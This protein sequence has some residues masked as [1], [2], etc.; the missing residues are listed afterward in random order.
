MI[1]YVYTVELFPT[2]LRMAALGACSGFS[3]IGQ[4]L[5]PWFSIY[6]ME[7]Y[8]FSPFLILGTFG[9]LASLLILAIP[10]ET[11]NKKMESLL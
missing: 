7:I 9:L 11:M 10:H 8:I 2:Y 5:A 6:M 3:R 1:I 4:T